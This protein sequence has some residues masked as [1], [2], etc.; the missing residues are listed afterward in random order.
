M[1][2]ESIQ[3]QYRTE[4]NSM[5]H[6]KA[7][8]K[9][10]RMRPYVKEM[11]FKGESMSYEG[12]GQV[13]ARE[14]QGR[15]NLTQFDDLEHFRRQITS[16][17][18]VVTLPIDAADVEKRLTDPQGDYAAACVRALERAY[19]HVVYDAMFATVKTGQQFATSV[20]ASTDGVLTV[21][22]TGGVAYD[23]FTTIKRQFLDNE[24][25]VDEDVPYIVGISGDEHEDIITIDQAINTRY[26][27]GDAPAGVGRIRTAFGV[28]FILF[29]ANVNN[30]VLGVTAGIRKGFALA[31][32]GVAVGMQ[33]NWTIEVDRRTDYVRV[34]QVQITG[35]LGAVRTEGKLLQQV[36]YTE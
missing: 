34:T 8:Q 24:V 15:F 6:L 10:S 3:T 7:Q 29:G 25:G 26:T 11:D 4:F 22:A 16:R 32:E 9:Q 20:S 27:G 35:V 14:L 19:D 28:D 30:P 13:E 36:N 17:A 1:P 21:T 5:M 33:R 18:F 12:L 2:M 31:R 23:D